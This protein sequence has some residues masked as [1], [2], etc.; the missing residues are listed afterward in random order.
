M[1]QWP[2][3]YLPP[4]ELARAKR[5]RACSRC[6]DIVA[7]SSTLCVTTCSLSFDLSP[8]LTNGLGSTFVACP[9]RRPLVCGRTSA[10]RSRAQCHARSLLVRRTSTS[11]AAMDCS[12]STRSARSRRNNMV[13]EAVATC[14]T[15]LPSERFGCACRRSTSSLGAASFSTHDVNASCTTWVCEEAHA[16]YMGRHKPPPMQPAA[17]AKRSP[18]QVPSPIQ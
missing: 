6:A 12:E 18:H 7:S 5:R 10:W 15:R 8:R 13:R 1:A 4:P 11:A 17:T 2:I 16:G 9:W 14:A 3:A